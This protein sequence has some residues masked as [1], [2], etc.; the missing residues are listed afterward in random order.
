[1][2]NEQNMFNGNQK[3]LK[4]YVYYCLKNL[5]L[6]IWKTKDYNIYYFQI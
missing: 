5:N 4:K 6:Y 2:Q 3:T 1:M